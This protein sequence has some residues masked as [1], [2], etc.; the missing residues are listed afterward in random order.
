VESKRRAIEEANEAYL[1]VTRLEP[2]PPKWVIAS[3]AAVGAMWS[4]F[5]LDFRRAPIPAWM[6]ADDELR[7]IYYQRLDAASEPI[8][9]AAKAAYTT[10]LQRS[11]AHQYFDRQSRTCEAWL[12]ENYRGQF[13]RVDEFRGHP[14]QI[15]SGLN[16]RPQPL[17]LGGLPHVALLDR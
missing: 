13:H 4:E 15:G 16:E 7:G 2:A 8:K 6:A 1:E 10:C 17:D 14:D 5:V 11:V 12:A 3:A 9:L